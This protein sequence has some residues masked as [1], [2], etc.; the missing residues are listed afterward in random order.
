MERVTDK[1]LEL[2]LTLGGSSRNDAVRM[3]R[4]LQQRREAE[5]W[6]PC[7]ERVPEEGQY[8]LCVYEDGE[9]VTD[10]VALCQFRYHNG[11]PIFHDDGSNWPAANITHWRPLPAPPTQ[12]AQR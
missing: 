3:A 6:I 4:E 7:G 9:C 12:E 8:V 1:D 5:R 11:E 2:I 10:N